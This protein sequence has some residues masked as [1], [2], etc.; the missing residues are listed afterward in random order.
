[1]R[2]AVLV[3]PDAQGRISGGYLYN[4]EMARHGAWELLSVGSADLARALEAVRDGLV[5]LD[6][7]WLT[8]QTFEPFRRLR[9]REIRLA[10]MLH[11]LPSRIASAER[12]DRV[13]PRPS[14]FER[15]AL[16][17]IGLALLPGPHYAPLLGELGVE[18]RVLEP[19]L[20]EAWRAPPRRRAG[21]CEL[22]SV[23]AVTPLKGFLDVA[24]ALADLPDAD[25]RWTVVGSLEVDRA[26]AASLR[27]RVRGRDNVVLA[28]QRSPVETRRIVQRA[29]VLILSSYEENHP[30]VLLEALAASVPSVAYAVGAAGSIV[31][32]GRTGLLAPL[33]DKSALARHVAELVADEPRRF[34]MASACWERQRLLPSWAEA[35]ARAR[36]TLT[37]G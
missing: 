24:D 37:G 25:H 35:A 16:S 14:P 19:G 33:G 18:V 32:H 3:Q 23:G 11:A 9:E 20:E 13:D 31:E 2:N 12:G 8:E 21:R 30:L 28:G 17:E 7:I 10:V 15:A 1:M 5:I 26:Y 6:S 36:T 29:D 22:V 34:A 27:E 4:A